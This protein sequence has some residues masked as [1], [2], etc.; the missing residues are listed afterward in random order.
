MSRIQKAARATVVVQ[1]FNFAGTFLSFVSVPL[2]LLWLG[3]ERYGLLL[4]G[5]A[6]AGYLMFAD[7]GLSWSSMLLISQAHGRGDRDQIAA[8]VR[9]SISLALVSAV[10]VGLVVW[11]AFLVLHSPSRPAWLPHHPEAAGLVLAVGSSVII[12]LLLSV[13][14]NIFNGMQEMHVAAGYQGVGRLLGTLASLGAAALG[15]P[16]GMVFGANVLCGLV[17]GLAAAM[18]CVR[19]HGWAFR[20]GPI[21]EHDQIRLQL[22]SG[23][24][25]FG[26]QIGGVLISTAPVFAI[27]SQASVAAVPCL[28][29]PLTLLNFP[30]SLMTSF[31]MTLQPGYGEAMGRGEQQW[32]AATIRSILYTGLVF[33]GLLSAGFIVLAQPFVQ[34]WTAGRLPLSPLMVIGALLIA[35]TGMILNIFRFALTGMNRHRF[36]AVSE[37]ANG[38]LS[39]PL[40]WLAVRYLGFAWVGFAMFLAAVTTSFWIL[41]RELRRNLQVSSIWPPLEFWVRWCLCTALALLA[42]ESARLLSLPTFPLISIVSTALLIT[43]AYALAILILLPE[44][45]RKIVGYVGMVKTR[46]FLSTPKPG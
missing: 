14:Y 20:W 30:L 36:A 4:T 28:T 37:L 3:Q 1:I 9:N 23:G 16:L 25:S 42:G 31:N 12:T 18:H 26:M 13:F 21:W 6:M 2:Y 38:L 11:S 19:R 44:E 32:V 5:L 17:C 35:V 46:F 41:P 7:A 24:K 45:W 15:E 39:F 33:T 8:I 27:S 40:A 34:L 43:S 10:L 29:I 22:R